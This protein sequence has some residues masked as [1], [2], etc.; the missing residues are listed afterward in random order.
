MGLD[1]TALR[2]F[3][4]ALLNAFPTPTALERM[5]RFEMDLN[6][7]TIAP[8]AA[9]LSDA[10]FALLQWTESQGR[11]EAL[12]AAA[13]R[14][15]TGNAAL[16]AFAS[17][18]GASSRGSVL[19]LDAAIRVIQQANRG[20]QLAQLLAF[21]CGAGGQ[22]G[23]LRA[24]LTGPDADRVAAQP[25]REDL[26]ALAREYDRLRATEPSGTKRTGL[27]EAV[28]SRVRA[29]APGA[30]ELMPEFMA[31][32]TGGER[33]VAVTLLNERAAP[34]HAAWLATQVESDQAFIVYHALQALRSLAYTSP[35]ESLHLVD[36]ALARASEALKNVS[37]HTD[38]RVALAAA[39]AT[40]AARRR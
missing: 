17:D 22:L 10:T 3:H 33:L 26:I 7:Y 36:T 20:G 4:E 15:N 34:E 11:T 6:Y 23:D 19:D 1:A 32:R 16:Q 2:T 18:R 13:C 14:S 9:N 27:F 12:L 21:A 37:E 29:L 39:L 30:S 5:L 35:V 31:G 8:A 40:L 38:R 28:V 24:R 25:R